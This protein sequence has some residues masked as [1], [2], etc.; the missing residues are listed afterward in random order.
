MSFHDLKFLSDKYNIEIGMLNAYY[1]KGLVRGFVDGKILK[2]D[3]NSLKNALINNKKLKFL[4]SSSKKTKYKAIELF[5]GCGGLA[6]GLERAGFN[7]IKA[8]DIDK[9]SIDT[10]KLNKP[11]WGAEVKDVKDLS[12]KEYRGS[13][14]L[15][16][17][18]FPC[19]AFSY[20][21]SKLG[22]A[23]TRGTLYFEFLRLIKEAKPKIFLAENVKGLL[24]HDSGRTIKVMLDGFKKAGY[25]VEYKLLK[26]Q[27][28][29]VPQKRERVIIVGVRKDLKF[30]YFFPTENSYF[31]PLS[32]ALSNITESEG[33][34]YSKAKESVLAKVPE[35][36]NW[37]DLPVELQ[38]S[39][40]GI[41]FNQ[42]GGKTGVARRLHLD[43]P[44]LTLTCS[45]SQKQTD[46]CHPIDTRPLNVREY[47]RIQ[48]F[49]D[50]WKFAGSTSSKYRQIGN[51]VPVNL[52]FHVG[53]S[54]IKAL[55]SEAI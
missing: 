26:S 49:P 11:A 40:M 31:I 1:K 18:G 42:G 38:K 44:S 37:R 17:G 47:A 7:T 43:E 33:I 54:I 55:D 9:D 19:Q 29:D 50:T 5:S 28:F 22:F 6:L 24:S 27:F 3:E 25:R 23:D 2:I 15:L 4:G 10:I 32:E 48:T 21:G 46:R 20:A 30:K 45:P 14:D 35:G 36:G 39:Y 41:S 8:F 13:L 53:K 51:A 16:A 34:L 12:L 52:A